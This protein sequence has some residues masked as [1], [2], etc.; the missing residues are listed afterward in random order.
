MRLIALA[1]R[2]RIRGKK[3]RTEE[4]VSIGIVAKAIRKDPAL[5]AEGTVGFWKLV[6]GVRKAS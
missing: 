2:R 6:E 3:E 5:H 1:G 4:Q